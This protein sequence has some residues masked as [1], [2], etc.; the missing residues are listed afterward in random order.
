MSKSAE[1]RQ[2]VKSIFQEN[3]PYRHIYHYTTPDVAVKILESKACS[4]FC[5]THYQFLNDDGEFSLGVDYVLDWLR[6]RVKKLADSELQN[7]VTRVE[8]ILR[9][10]VE[11]AVCGCFTPWILSFSRDMDSVSQWMAYTD[12]QQG[13]YAI[14]VNF[15]DLCESIIPIRSIDWVECRDIWIAAPCVYVDL[16]KPES[17][18]TKVFG[19]LDRL[20]EY[21]GGIDLLRSKEATIIFARLA[22]LFASLIK[23]V[24][25]KTERE[26]R[27]VR[28][29]DESL[30]PAQVEVIG[31]KPRIRLQH[32]QANKIV[33]KLVV[34][35]HGDRKRLKIIADLLSKKYGF[36]VRESKTSYTA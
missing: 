34:S 7:F 12:H 35:H 21:R 18:K 25:F 29:T 22:L 19:I 15:D 20:L 4:E 9:P 5:C 16:R 17:S 10:S 26:W 24:D 13:G 28:L 36:V 33:G 14:G 27:V 6:E 32:V 2:I 3:M 31:G 11:S 8:Q 1:F 30:N 23:S